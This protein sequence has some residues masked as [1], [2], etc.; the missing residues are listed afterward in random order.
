MEAAIQS[1]SGSEYPTPDCLTPEQAVAYRTSGTLP[2]DR[3][4]HVAL[5]RDCA[6]LLAL[7]DQPR[8]LARPASDDPRYERHDLLRE[9][10]RRTSG[11]AALSTT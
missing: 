5:C 7:L 8:P 9:V 11:A 10:L 6:G 1:A 2:R 3:Q 4:A